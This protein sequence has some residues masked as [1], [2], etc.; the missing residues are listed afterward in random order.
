[1]RDSG[2][3]LARDYEQFIDLWGQ[4]L[5]VYESVEDAVGDSTETLLL[6]ALRIDVHTT[7][8]ENGGRSERPG[9]S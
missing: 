5:D 9:R 7:P 4:R 6:S 8:R 1:M 3:P 2:R